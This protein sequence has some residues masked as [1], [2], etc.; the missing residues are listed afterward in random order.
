MTLVTAIHTFLQNVGAK[1]LSLQCSTTNHCNMPQLHWTIDRNQEFTNF[2][3]LSTLTSTLFHF[4]K[5]CKMVFLN[6]VNHIGNTSFSIGQTYHG[7]W[8]ASSFSHVEEGAAENVLFCLEG[9]GV[10]NASDPQFQFCSP[11]LPAINDRSLMH[12]SF[13]VSGTSVTR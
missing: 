13:H 5:F 7:I 1:Q 4:V 12:V 2:C 8:D 9:A 11:P 3:Q 6:T 10:Q